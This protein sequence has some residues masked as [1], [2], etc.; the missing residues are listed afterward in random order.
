MDGIITTYCPNIDKQEYEMFA[1][2]MVTAERTR[3]RQIRELASKS[4]QS[5]LN[6]SKNLT[7]SLTSN[8]DSRR[9]QKSSLAFS[10]EAAAATRN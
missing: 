7:P 6:D 9:N 8:M 5:G 2:Q 10:R 1:E 4:N 3:N